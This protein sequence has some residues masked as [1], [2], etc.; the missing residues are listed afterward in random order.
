MIRDASV[1]ASINEQ[2]TS[3]AYLVNY[4]RS[5]IIGGPGPVNETPPDEFYNLALV[6]AYCAL[7]EFPTQ[8]I[9][10]RRLMCR[11]RMLGA[12]MEAAKTQLKWVD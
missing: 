12:R 9:S 7:D 5:S 8:L 3:I 2:W 10:E 11:G 4:S 1:R 6:L